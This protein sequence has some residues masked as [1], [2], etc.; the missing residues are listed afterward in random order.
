[1]TKNAIHFIC[2]TL[3]VL[4]VYKLLSWLFVQLDNLVSKQ[5]EYT[6]CPIYDNIQKQNGPYFFDR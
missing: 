6:Y 3:Y 1:M 2:G 4:K 5:L